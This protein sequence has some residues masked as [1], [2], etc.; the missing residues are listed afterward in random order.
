MVLQIPKYIIAPREEL[1]SQ[2]LS[3]LKGDESDDGGHYITVW[4]PRQT[5]K[6]WIMQQV[7]SRLKQDTEFE[8]VIL[9]LQEIYDST[10]VN[11]VAR[12]YCQGIDRTLLKLKKLPI[13][14]LEDFYLLFERGNLE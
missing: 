10:D 5:G 3:Q 9:P 1:I 7:V 8:T 4:A 12:S 14:T 13:K 2:V 6:T 11:R